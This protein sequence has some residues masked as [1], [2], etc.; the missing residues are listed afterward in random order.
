[1]N[2]KCKIAII[3][4]AGVPGRYGGFETL[5]HHLVLQLNQQFDLT[6]YC[7]Q[8]IYTPS[9]RVKTWNGAR[10]IYLPF[11]ANGLQSIIYDFIAIIHALF[12]ADRLVILGVSGCSLLPLVRLFSRKPIIVNIDGLEWKRDKWS[13]PVK[14]FLKFS[15]WCAVK[16][17]HAD[18]TDNAAIQQ[19]TAQTYGTLSHTIAYGADHCA[20]VN[21][22]DQYKEQYPFLHGRYAFKVCRIEPE[23]NVHLILEAFAN[24]PHHKLVIIG[25]WKNSAYGINLKIKYAHLPNIFLLDPIYEPHLLNMLRGNCAAYIHG[26]SAGGTNPSLVEAMYLKLP[27]IAFNVSYNRETTFNRAIY[28][29]TAAELVSQYNATNALALQELSCIMHELALK[30]YT[31]QRIASQY[32]EVINL[33]V[34]QRVKHKAAPAMQKLNKRWALQF[35]LAQFKL[36]IK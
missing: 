25:N 1:M 11:N 18:I 17:S 19:Y 20:K 8:K 27:I 30:H 24:M 31:W 5:A 13:K 29:T 16:F 32:A 23:N 14:W 2:V 22:E 28:F 36:N 15:E 21:I 26:H 12:T 35:G 4:S 34:H 7:T 6:V 3:G 10:L 33:V 9:E